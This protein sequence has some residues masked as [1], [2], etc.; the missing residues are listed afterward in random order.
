MIKPS[1]PRMEE[2]VYRRFFNILCM[3]HKL[4]IVSY[5]SWIQISPGDIIQYRYSCTR[6]IRHF[7]TADGWVVHHSLKV[8]VPVVHLPLGSVLGVVLGVVLE[9][10][11]GVVLE[12]VDLSVDGSIGF[13]C[14]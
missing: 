12:V 10:V 9:V 4:F 5:Q 2:N 8:R 6:T 14:G 13:C 1:S 11:F 3:Q 7:H